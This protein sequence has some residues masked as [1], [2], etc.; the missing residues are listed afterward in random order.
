MKENKHY[1]AEAF[2]RRKY[3]AKR[4]TFFFS[5]LDETIRY[6]CFESSVLRILFVENIVI[7]IQGVSLAASKEFFGG[8][9]Y[10][11]KYPIVRLRS[12]EKYVKT[13]KQHRWC[14]LKWHLIEIV[15]W[16]SEFPNIFAAPDN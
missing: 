2:F 13:R 8:G 3:F 16:L 1:D 10:A 5:T 9:F 12:V 15:A 14:T 11:H 4:N 6:M 7:R